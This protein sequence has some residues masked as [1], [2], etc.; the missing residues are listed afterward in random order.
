MDQIQPVPNLMSRCPSQIERGCCGADRP[1]GRVQNHDAVGRCRSS[2]KLS[3]AEQATT[4]VADPDIEKA[5]R[6]PRISPSCGRRL[7]FIVSGKG[8]RTSLHTVDP[9]GRFAG[10]IHRRESKLNLSIRHQI[11]P[12]LG[13]VSFVGIGGAVVLVK[14]GDLTLDLGIGD[15]LSCVAVYDVHYDGNGDWSCAAASR[16]PQ[17]K[18]RR[19]A[20]DVYSILLIGA[21]L[22]QPMVYFGR[23]ARAVRWNL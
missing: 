17:H 1:K 19:V 3:I 6:R 23:A 16:S 2:W 20:F 15:I 7:Y 8:L 13:N 22:K 10:W 4:Q 21:I 18:S 12:N 9:V 14:Y 5:V 11:G